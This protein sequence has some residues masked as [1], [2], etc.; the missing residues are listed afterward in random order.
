MAAQPYLSIRSGVALGFVAYSL[1]ARLAD[2]E[3]GLEGARRRNLPGR[4][5][6]RV[7]VHGLPVQRLLIHSGYGGAGLERV[8]SKGRHR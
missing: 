4:D 7:P 6:V 2:A 5:Q 3:V 8:R 1:G